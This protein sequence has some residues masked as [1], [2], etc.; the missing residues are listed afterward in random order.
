MASM[1]GL[2]PMTQGATFTPRP[3]QSQGVPSPSKTHREHNPGSPDSGH[4]SSHSE[5]SF[6][7]SGSTNVSA[8]NPKLSIIEVEALL[9]EKVRSKYRD[10]QQGF[11]N[12]DREQNL[13]ITKGEFRRVLELY[14][15][16]LTSEQFDQVMSKIDTNRNGTVKY[17]DFLDK[18][19]GAR[20]SSENRWAVPAT[21][22]GSKYISQQAPPKEINVDM[23]EKMLKDKINKNLKN[24]CKGLRLYDYNRDGRVQR[25]ELRKV[26]EN[27]CFKFTDQQ[28][29]KLWQRYDFHH[30]GMVDYRDFLQRLGVNVVKSQQPLSDSS[31]SA[32]NWNHEHTGQQSKRP[33]LGIRGGTSVISG[34]TFDQI[35]L[36]FRKKMIENR[37][38][39]KRAFLA[40]DKVKDGL[41]PI[42]DV[43]SILVN[44]T[45]PMSDQLF[46][47]LM[48]R[49]GIKASGRVAW[50][51]FLEKFQDAQN[52]GNGQTIPIKPGH[53]YFPI[54][55]D[56]EK[57]SVKDILRM[58]CEKVELGSNN[59]K[60]AFLKIDIDRKGRITKKEL[61]SVFELFK[62]RVSDDQFKELISILDPEKTN[63]ISY[64]RF[65]DLF[66]E[67]ETDEGHKWLISDHR[68]NSQQRPAILAWETVE[69]ILKEKI[70][71]NFKPIGDA[72][73]ANDPKN[74]GRIAHSDLKN[75]IDKYVLPVS[76]DHFENMVLR[77]EERD[78]E[79]VNYVEFMEKLG[80]DV[81]PGDVIGLSTQITDGSSAAETKRLQDQIYRQVEADQ[82]VSE[83]TDTLFPEEILVKIKDRMSQHSTKIRET[84]LI[85][86]KKGRRKISKKVF[87]G[88]LRDYGILMTDNVY[89]EVCSKLQFHKGF[90]DYK[91]FVANFEDPRIDGPGVDIVRSG[92]HRVNVARGDELGM[93]AMECEAK[94][95]NKLREGFADL[96][97]AFYKF[98]D[99]HQG[100]LTRA[101]F[102][103]LLDSFMFIISDEE[104]K[105][106]AEK[107]GFVKGVRVGYQEFL[108]KFE[109]RD[110][111]EG[112]PWLTSCHRYN[113]TFDATPMK[114]DEVHKILKDKAHR[115]W[116][117]LAKAF[118]TM[119][120]SGNGIITKK[121]LRD[122]LF[123]FILPMNKDDFNH[124]WRRYDLEGKGYISHTDFLEELVGHQFA[125]GD[126]VGPSRRI[127]NDSYM[128]L[129]R[130]HADQQAK[131]EMITLKTV[132]RA[133]EMTAEEVH[134][135]LKDKIRETYESFNKAFRKFD[136]DNSGFISVAQ[137]QRVLI[138]FNYFLDDDQFFK[139]LD[140]LGLQ[141]NKSKLSYEAFLQGFQEG[142]K[143][144][145]KP[146]SPRTETKEYSAISVYDAENKLKVNV[147]R[148]ADTIQAALCAFDRKNNGRISKGDFRSVLDNFCFKLS[149]KQF[150][151]IL[152]GILPEGESQVD[153]PLFLENYG[154]ISPKGQQQEPDVAMWLNNIERR[155]AASS[156]KTLEM[157]DIHQSLHEQVNAR[158]YGLAKAFAEIDY[159]QI[160]V[161][162]LEDF[163]DVINKHCM[164]LTDQQFQSIWSTLPVNEFGNLDY[165]R[166]LKEYSSDV[167]VQ[168]PRTAEM[169]LPRTPQIDNHQM[170]Q[171]SLPPT[172]K[173]FLAPI[174]EDN[175]PAN[176]PSPA[177]FQHRP[178]TAEIT[179]QNGRRSTSRMA[180]V[181]KS[182]D[183]LD[184]RTPLPP[185]TGR[186]SRAY[187]PLVNAEDIEG[188]L[189]EKIK[190]NW[191]D[192]QRQCRICDPG[193][194]GQ[195]DVDAMKEIIQRCGAMMTEFEFVQLSTKYDLKNS[196][197]FSYQD[198]LRH[199]VL[200]MKQN[201]DIPEE[202]QKF[203][204]QQINTPSTAQA[205]SGQ[206]TD[207]YNSAMGRIQKCVR[208]SWKEMRRTFRGIDKQGT[209]MI[210]SIDFRMVLKQYNINLSEDEFFH[211][212][213]FYD[214]NLGGN[215]SYND[216]IKACLKS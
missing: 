60:D 198:F 61:R 32:L 203:R 34:M 98:D 11:Q 64:Q 164:R 126:E 43:K 216:F 44:F 148:Q 162:S 119:D 19:Y 53:K 77:C 97:G 56:Q 50:E 79:K 18:F 54:R 201:S 199:F 101:N 23:V 68:F 151:H 194:T 210:S 193:N 6:Q 118:R 166:F 88:V 24:V 197:K 153:Y 17:C 89:D 134:Q 100:C 87:R 189:R 10:L 4:G 86:D 66:E 120:G 158:F 85:F 80:V 13:S 147:G 190:R 92:N 110:T 82:H 174:E 55:G 29:D 165:R 78:D 212:M 12:Y 21:P 214:K 180:N 76:E 37:A 81:K 84:F 127:I 1:L 195:I 140:K 209:G 131:Q 59:L 116:K 38:N 26:L 99:T 142:R 70:E 169:N 22:G 104:F 48:D 133:A 186:R 74:E 102:R 182:L 205:P 156:P 3:A 14:C 144:H 173:E 58:L 2:R 7:D 181:T 83:R 46:H 123:K 168:L 20:S 206:K 91:D 114:A 178:K 136:K 69:D 115:Q 171:G 49:C 52:D 170:P 94:L 33:R 42:E 47:Q 163:R 117:D 184:L 75:I 145:Y 106:L 150:K 109:V 188:K 28:Y 167:N 200:T 172:P 187:T 159:A 103:R 129:D 155:M 192:I 15:I 62:I 112:H 154:N 185:G 176:T 122:V 5:K 215:V 125:P 146:R 111:P 30:T 143:E 65:L 141:T 191:K 39:L 73:V 35:E 130:H 45:I 128:N 196:G 157:S 108:D 57:S 161:V 137:I 72:I 25:H 213:T 160:G 40:F 183:Q 90:M 105:K 9:R 139:L 138:D 93:S 8:A 149:D 67:R 41:L 208:S 121:E 132:Y 113:D 135:E 51:W 95:R 202:T 36:E 152:S 16:S 27:Y 31:K 179:N 71:E 175:G 124:L 211:M 63:N 107:F 96:R 177:I 204:R 207:S